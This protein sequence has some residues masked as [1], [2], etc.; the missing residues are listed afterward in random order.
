MWNASCMAWT[1]RLCRERPCALKRLAKRS[2]EVGTSWWW[3]FRRTDTPVNSFL[4]SLLC[5]CYSMQYLA[6]PQPAPRHRTAS[7]W[8]GWRPICASSKT[9]ESNLRTFLTCPLLCV[10]GLRALSA[11]LHKPELTE[12]HDRPQL[13]CL[14]KGK[15]VHGLSQRTWVSSVFRKHLFQLICIRCFFFILY[16]FYF[17]KDVLNT[18]N[19]LSNNVNILSVEFVPTP[20]VNAKHKPVFFVCWLCWDLLT[21]VMFCLA[22]SMFNSCSSLA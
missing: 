20:V 3:R 12:A 10:P 5:S 16:F 18:V 4:L 15:S 8:G 11:L 7:S 14:R 2:L 13:L 9:C 22:K 6:S 21:A 1:G 19:N 17:K